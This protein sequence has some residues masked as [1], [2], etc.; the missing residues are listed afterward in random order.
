MLAGC[1]SSKDLL[2]SCQS[3][4]GK[5]TRQTHA[6]ILEKSMLHSSHVWRKDHNGFSH[7]EPGFIEHVVNKK[8]EVIRDYLPL[9]DNTLLLVTNHCLKNRSYVNVIVG[10]Q[11][12]GAA[13][14]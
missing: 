2:Q 5:I 8:A 14:A 6:K 9:D 12:T 3:S 10:G 1:T 13:M 4:I 11:A 7:K